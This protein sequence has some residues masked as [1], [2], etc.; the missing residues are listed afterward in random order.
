[1]GVGHSDHGVQL[2]VLVRTHGGGVL[3]R[4]PVG[5]AGLGVVEPVV[6][7]LPDVV[8]VDM[9]DALGHLRAG[10]AT[11]GLDELSADLD[12][13]LVGCLLFHQVVPEGVPGTNDFDLTDE[14]GVEGRS[15]DTNPV[16][17]ADEDLVTEE[18]GAPESTVGVG[19][20][21]AHLSGHIWKLTENGLGG[22]VL[23][24]GVVKMLIVLLDFVVADHLLEELEGV[25]I[26][27]VDAW[28][29]VEN[30]DVGVVHLVVTHH[31]QCG[32]VDAFVT[33]GALGSRLLGNGAE[34][35]VYLFDEGV[36]VDGAGADNND[37]LAGVVG[38]AVALEAVSSEVLEVVVVTADR[39]AHH[40]VSVGVE[41]ASL[42]GGGL[43]VLVQKSVLGGLLLLGELK[44]SGIDERVRNAVTDKGECTAEAALVAG[45][46]HV[47]DLAVDIGGNASADGLDLFG[48]LGLGGVL[49]A[50]H[51]HLGEEV[52]STSGLEG[53]L[54]RA[55]VNV[56]S[57][58]IEQR[59]TVSQKCFMGDKG[60]TYLAVCEADFSVITLIPLSRVVVS[61]GSKL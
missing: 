51:D 9:R 25:V 7:Q 13:G 24:L 43:E 37:V 36:V 27:V 44:F 16:H 18:V 57:D 22:V 35:L 56:D 53:V 30:A 21:L 46:V 61:K 48:Q 20:V 32:S 58:A 8:G 5:E 47:S 55:S 15:G 17:L 23:L 50:S 52:S 28:G 10:D 54:T 14:V 1:M 26:L 40:V 19:V 38:S 2:E 33:V 3:D 60:L 4:S 42:E 34:G 31:E 12:V 11:V 41:V 49:R 59:E 45:D 6:A 39:L 29:I